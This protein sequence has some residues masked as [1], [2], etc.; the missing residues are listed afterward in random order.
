MRCVVEMGSGGMTYIP[1]FTKIGIGIHKF[2]G[3]NTES[4]EMHK[5]TFLFQKERERERGQANE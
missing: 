5:P 2:V 1:S 3:G 4:I